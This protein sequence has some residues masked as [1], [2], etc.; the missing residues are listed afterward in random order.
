MVFLVHDKESRIGSR[1][2]ELNAFMTQAGGPA[3]GGIYIAGDN[4]NAFEFIPERPAFRRWGNLP[5]S[6]KTNAELTNEQLWGNPNYTQVEF[7]YSFTDFSDVSS[8]GNRVTVYYGVQKVL[9]YV[10]NPNP[11]YLTELGWVRTLVNYDQDGNAVSITFPPNT[12][13]GVVNGA[14]TTFNYGMGWTFFRQ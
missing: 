3:G 13:T 12:M 4:S 8:G 9:D 2:D 11:G 5:G 10:N 6:G 14:Q 7:E 1:V